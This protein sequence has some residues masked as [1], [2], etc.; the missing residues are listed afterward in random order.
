MLRLNRD[1]RSCLYR[2]LDAYD[3]Y[4]LFR[5]CRLFHHDLGKYGKLGCFTHAYAHHKMPTHRFLLQIDCFRTIYQCKKAPAQWTTWFLAS[6]GS[7]M[8]RDLLTYVINNELPESDA[9]I[10]IFS[11]LVTDFNFSRDRGKLETLCQRHTGLRYLEIILESCPNPRLWFDEAHMKC[12]ALSI[13]AGLPEPGPATDLLVKYWGLPNRLSLSLTLPDYVSHFHQS[14]DKYHWLS[15]HT[16]RWLQALLAGTFLGT[17]IV[18]GF[19]RFFFQFDVDSE[20]LVES[21]GFTLLFSG[22]VLIIQRYFRNKK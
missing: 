15:Y 10:S 19:H 3:F 18:T 22:A 17:A 6:L 20:V 8:R 1:E 16:L 11:Q 9:L 7:A 12:F 5:T 13:F 21:W 14:F 2:Y 4:T